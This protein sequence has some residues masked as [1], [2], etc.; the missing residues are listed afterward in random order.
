M[1]PSSAP[2]SPASRVSGNKRS[3]RRRRCCPAPPTTRR[4]RAANQNVSGRG[5]IV[6]YFFLMIRRPP[7]STLFPYTTLFRSVG[8]M[9]AILGTLDDA[10]D[11]AEIVMDLWLSA[12]QSGEV[13]QVFEE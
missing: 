2:G 1:K 8:E 7:R 10:R 5:G 6:F 9:D 11:F 12:R 13:E 3:S 4:T